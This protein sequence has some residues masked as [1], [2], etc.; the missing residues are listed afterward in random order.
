VDLTTYVF[1]R[2][3]CREERE[4]ERETE[5]QTTNQWQKYIKV[6]KETEI[7]RKKEDK[8]KNIG[9]LKHRKWATME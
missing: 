1:K 4:R 7:L 2:V 3:T 9:E 8:Q 5:T 6:K